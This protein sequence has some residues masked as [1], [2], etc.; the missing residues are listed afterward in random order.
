MLDGHGLP[1]AFRIDHDQPLMT[2]QDMFIAP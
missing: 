2:E 1:S